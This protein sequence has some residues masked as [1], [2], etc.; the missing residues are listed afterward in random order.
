MYI[1]LQSKETESSS[2]FIPHAA[3]KQSQFMDLV[4]AAAAAKPTGIL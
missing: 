1:F 4:M 2:S 3:G